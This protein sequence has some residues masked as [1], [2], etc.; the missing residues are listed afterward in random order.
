M[1]SQLDGTKNKYAVNAWV[2]GKKK[3]LELTCGMQTDTTRATCGK[4]TLP[5]RVVFYMVSLIG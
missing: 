5:F 2:E 4:W 1:F 3:T